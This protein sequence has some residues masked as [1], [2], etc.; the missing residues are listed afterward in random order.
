MSESKIFSLLLNSVNNSFDHYK[1][2][3]NIDRTLINLNFKPK[4]L[5]VK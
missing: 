2:H 1:K 5:S 3:S 4:N